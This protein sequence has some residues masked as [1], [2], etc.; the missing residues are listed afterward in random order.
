MIVPDAAAFITVP[1]GAA[2]SNPVWSLTLIL[3]FAPNLDVIEPDIGLIKFIPK[4]T[5]WY[6]IFDEVFTFPVVLTVL[7]FAT[8]TGSSFFTYN[9][10][11]I[12]HY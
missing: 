6:D 9:L 7:F 3:L 5:F 11:F 10:N 4:F 12:K 8:W 1:L 2:I